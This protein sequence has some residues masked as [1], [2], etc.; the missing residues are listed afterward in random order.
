ME[1]HLFIYYPKKDL[2]QLLAALHVCVGLPVRLLDEEGAVLL[3][4]GEPFSYCK[5]SEKCLT[6][7]HSCALE[8][9]KAGRQAID[10]GEPYIFCCYAGV[11]HVIYPLVNKDRLFGSVLLGPFLMDGIDDDLIKHL[12]RSSEIPTNTALELYKAATLIPDE[13][14]ERVVQISRL[15]Y[16]LVN[17]LVSGSRELQNT[18]RERLLHLSMVSESIRRYKQME[19]DAWDTYP[20]KKERA[21]ISEIKIGDPESI[22]AAFSDYMAC[23]IQF[24]K[25]D[26]EGIK[27]RLIELCSVV[28]RAF[29]ERGADV[30]TALDLNKRL[31]Q[32][33]LNAYNISDISFGVHDDLEG[34]VNSMTALPESDSKLMK[35]ATQFIRA[36]LS[37]KILLSDLAKE[38]GFSVPYL[39]KRF[40]Q[41]TGQT[42]RDYLNVQR[43]EEAKRLLSETDFPLIDI[44]IACGFADQSYFTKIFK[45]YTGLPPHQFR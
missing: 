31:I 6:N 34:F 2:D 37:E 7:G 28:S 22:R 29:I 12:A 8:H 5:M 32:H 17:S 39:S 41:M 16:Y 45:K 26:T 23:L 14:P 3:S 19:H 44:A 4:H 35:K 27:Y 13:T 1:S 25:Y 10:F 40:K 21:L 42:F 20:L 43:V 38:L 15:L 9:G 30:R 36:N 33:I 11:Y 24:E 18:N